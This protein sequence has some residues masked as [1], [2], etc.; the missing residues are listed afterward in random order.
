MYHALPATVASCARCAEVVERAH[1]DYSATGDVL[2]PRCASVGSIEASEARAVTTMKSLAWGNLSFAVLAWM[3]NPFL[4]FT[5]AAIV[6]GVYVNRSVH[7]DFY[8]RRL[9]P[10]G[11]LYGAVAAF[12]AVV[13]ALPLLIVIAR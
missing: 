6:N 10:R 8:Q 13:S 5:I 12:A 11:R 2:C 7:G 9:G 4:V 3:F 1:A